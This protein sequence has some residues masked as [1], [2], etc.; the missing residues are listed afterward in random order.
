MKRILWVLLV[1]L[2]TGTL[3]AQEEQRIAVPR[4]IEIPA[5]TVLCPY[6]YNHTFTAGPPSA[7]APIASEFPATLQA[8]IAGS[9]WNQ[10]AA[11]KHFGHTFTFPSE[12]HCCAMTSGRLEVTIKALQG[13]GPNSATSVNDA[14][15]AITNG[16]IFAS[17]QPWLNT[18]ISTGTTT[19]VV[20]PLTAAQ[21]ASGRISFYVQDDSAVLGAKLT[22][23]GCCIRKP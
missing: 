19:T 9:V 4:P 23:T 17:K 11:N 21:L 20:F 5:K 2:A 15:H 13:G 14:V 16:A 18:T 6:P 10:T 8:A 1:L 12:R 3:L 7:P 22:V